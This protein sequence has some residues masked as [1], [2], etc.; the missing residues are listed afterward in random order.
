[1]NKQ[2][3][4]KGIGSV[5]AKPDLIVITMKLTT[6][7]ADYL[8]T[9]AKASAEVEAIRSAIAEA[10]L[11]KTDLKTSRF[12]VN[13]VFDGIKDQN[14]NYSQVLKGY[15]C[16]H[17]LSLEFDFSM[18]LLSDT[19]YAIAHCVAKPE[20]SIQFSV[21]DKN[22]VSEQLLVSA[23]E[24]AKSKAEILARATGVKL[25]DLVAIDYSWG[26]LRLY[27]ETEYDSC[28][29]CSSMEAEPI[30]IEP[31]DIDVKDS[32]TFVWEIVK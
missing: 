22:A 3:T 13:T 32:V 5:S 10:G 7:K 25:G 9:V 31:E 29:P 4:V 2:I 11:N 23:A 24:N 30:D 12:A 27:S 21:K 14:G 19:I 17:G 28:S 16:Q 8:K 20:F 1:M 6:Q 18:K 15:E 26:E